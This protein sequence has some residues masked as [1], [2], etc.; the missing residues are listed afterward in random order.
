MHVSHPQQQALALEL[1]LGRHQRD[2]Q[3]YEVDAWPR[4]HSRVLFTLQTEAESGRDEVSVCK[5]IF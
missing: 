2:A 3:G 5:L 4:H 1:V